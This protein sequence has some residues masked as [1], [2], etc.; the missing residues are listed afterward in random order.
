MVFGLVCALLSTKLVII[1]IISLIKVIAVYLSY[2][3]YLVVIYVASGFHTLPTT[4]T[5]HT[6]S[7]TL[8][9]IFISPY[10]ERIYYLISLWVDVNLSTLPTPFYY[11]SNP[12]H[13][14]A[15]R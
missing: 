1:I 11:T 3:F 5:S 9:F 8:I 15:R 7:H 14:L 10:A 4:F 12:P 2:F 13:T 6:Y